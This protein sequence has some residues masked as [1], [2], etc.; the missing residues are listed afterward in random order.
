VRRLVD[1]GVAAVAATTTPATGRQDAALAYSR[2]MRTHGVST[3]PDPDPQGDF[4]PF[5]SNVSKPASTA[6]DDACRHLRSSGAAA[7]PQQREEKLAFGLRVARW[8][9]SH[10]SRISPTR[11]ASARTARDRPER[12][13]IPGGGDGLRGSGAAGSQPAMTASPARVPGRA[14]SRTLEGRDRFAAFVAHELRAPVALQRA[15]VEVALAD[16][17]AD[18]AALRAMGA[19][20]LAA[21]EQQQRLIDALLELTR[22]RCRLRRREPVDLVAIAAEV[23]RA[24]DL[25]GLESIV[26]LEPAW[27]VGDPELLA[28]LCANLVSD[29]IRHNVAGGRVEV[30]THAAT[31]RAV[32]SLANT[33]PP[34]QAEQLRRFS[35]PADAA[36]G[37]GLGLAVVHAIADAHGALVTAEARPG[38]GLAIDVGFRRRL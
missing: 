11:P 36:A 16:P 8:V 10:G 21:C 33:G 22:S 19:R 17:D 7:T 3:F 32:L 13:A 37:A 30:T 23:L 27:T 29:A 1:A 9:R 26:V 18:S 5:E 38:G 15:L 25:S 35:E 4:P 28:R 24:H 14:V 20:V 34:I 2:C 12:A 31:G 6:A